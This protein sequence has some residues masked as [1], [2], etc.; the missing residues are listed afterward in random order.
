MTEL[1]LRLITIFNWLAYLCSNGTLNSQFETKQ[2]FTS[3]V[4]AEISFG[5]HR[6]LPLDYAMNYFHPVYTHSVY[7]FNMIF[8]NHTIKTK[9]VHC[10]TYFGAACPV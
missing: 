6:I 9:C 10:C 4:E 8:I 7:V 3:F 1:Y 5:I 2:K